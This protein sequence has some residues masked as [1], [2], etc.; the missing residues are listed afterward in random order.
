MICDV[1][2]VKGC[3]SKGC[4]IWRNKTKDEMIVPIIKKWFKFRN[5]VHSKWYLYQAIYLRWRRT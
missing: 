4:E 5:W 2:G 3:K 1:H